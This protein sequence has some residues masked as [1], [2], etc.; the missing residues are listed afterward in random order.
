MPTSPLLIAKSPCAQFDASSIGNQ[1]GDGE[2]EAL[3]PDIGDGIY[4]NFNGI[5]ISFA[6]NN[7]VGRMLVQDDVRVCGKLKMAAR[8]RK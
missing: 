5:C 6:S 7:I 3:K 2:P 1:N 8:N 4:G